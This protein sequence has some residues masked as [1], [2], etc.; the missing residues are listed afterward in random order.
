[1]KKKFVNIIVAQTV[2]ELEFILKK[3]P[4]VENLYCVPIN[5]TV[6]IFCIEKNIPYL[7][8]IFYVKN[9]FHYQ[10]II[11][12]EKMIRKISFNKDFKISEKINIKSFLRFY[13]NSIIFLIEVI[14]KINK[15]KKI[16]Y[17]YASGWFNYLDTYSKK[18]HYIS[19]ILKK[20]FK[21]KVIELSKNKVNLPKDYKN[22]EYHVNS[23]KIPQN[24]KIIILSNIGYNFFRLLKYFFNSKLKNTYILTPNN[25]KLNKFK[26]I[27]FFFLKL[28]FFSFKETKLKSKKL[29][30]LPSIKF[31]FKNY[32]LTKLLNFRICQ[33]KNNIIINRLK[34]KSLEKFFS[35]KNLSLVIS[36]NSRN[37]DGLFMDYAYQKKIPFFCIPH[38]TISQS[39]NKFDKVYKNII[40]ESIT[41]P[42]SI[43]VSQSR[44]SDRYYKQEK[45]FF[46]GIINTGNI[47]FAEKKNIKKN[48]KILYAVTMKDFENIQY[49]G[50]EMYYEYLDN[51]SF[52]NKFAVK[53]N[54]EI[55]VKNH[56]SINFLT[57]KLKNYYNNLFFSDENIQKILRDTFCTI[58][59]SST[60]IEDSLYSKNPVI[61]LDRWKR[62][63]HCKTFFNTKKNYQAIQYVTN[64]KKLA[65]CILNFLNKKKINFNQYL[66]EGMSEDNIKN[67]L[68]KNL[69]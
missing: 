9:S 63:K 26:K 33:E 62:Y 65:D 1:M 28:K 13:F 56:P 4:K 34:F 23:S 16:K 22:I 18:N 14:E 5:L 49:L 31:K 69:N 25:L 50:V 68:Q 35:S 48:K 46:R 2:E 37:L 47:I 32:N 57:K 67:F 43:F 29:I 59:F 8:P 11:S 61:L 36:N 55:I 39:F 41:Y 64:E 66:K 15:K 38:G 44:I 3:I 45:S 51:L 40:A 24:N 60:V 54:L 20:L 6:H 21:N 42:N 7:N 19:F 52:L 58:S 30:K 53:N 12:S 27:I 17:I 10:A